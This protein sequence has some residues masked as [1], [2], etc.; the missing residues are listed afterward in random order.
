MLCGHRGLVWSVAFSP[1]AAVWSAAA[2]T[3]P[4]ASGTTA[5]TGEPIVLAGHQGIVWGTAFSADGRQVV[6]A[7]NDTTVR[8]WKSSGTGQPV[9]LHGFGAS[10]ES[11]RF[12][13]AG[14]F[15]SAHDDGTVR[16]WE[17]LPCRPID[18]LVERSRQQSTRELTREERDSY[19]NGQ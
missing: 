9:V 16:V 4:H 15:V 12:V 10:V 14:H 8:G 11:A 3:A 2:T 6:T 19:L 5:G 7:G 18:E 13:A 1:T 17:C